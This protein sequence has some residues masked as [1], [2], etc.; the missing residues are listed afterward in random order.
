[1]RKNVGYMNSSGEIIIRIKGHSKNGPLTPDNYD[2]RELRDLLS[3]VENLIDS[4]YP[5][6]VK[7]L[8][9][10]YEVKK[11]SVVNIFR[12]SKQIA[13]S[14]MAVA[15]M[16]GASN[17]LEGVEYRT[18]KAFCDLQK[19]AVSKGYTYEFFGSEYS[20]SVLNISPE[21]KLSI[22][23]SVWAEAEVYLYGTLENAGGASKSNVHIR[24]KEYGLVVVESNRDF[25]KDQEDNFLYHNFAIRAATRV[26]VISGEID[27]SNMRMLEMTPFNPKY[28]SDYLDSL[29]SKATRNW[30]DV[31]D[32]NLWLNEIRGKNG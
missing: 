31:E 10:S 16:I 1:M 24:T 30:T 8:P 12:T 22:S 21:S 15:S 7:R 20:E 13:V 4:F 29:I 6:D 3:I 2:I 28:D 9:V 11:G 27:F 5:A 32:V 14:V 18:A 17:S 23:E 26:N 19:S 25:L